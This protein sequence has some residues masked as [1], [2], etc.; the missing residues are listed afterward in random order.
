MIDF[1]IDCLLP[2]MFIMGML[3]VFII[4]ERIADFLEGTEKCYKR[5]EKKNINRIY[6]N[7]ILY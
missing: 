7:R 2:M 3:L 1:L 4:L 5:E 6:K